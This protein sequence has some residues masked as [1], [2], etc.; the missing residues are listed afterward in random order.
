MEQNNISLETIRRELGLSQNGTM[1]T[2]SRTGET[3]ADDLVWVNSDGAGLPAVTT[4]VEDP[5]QVMKEEKELKFGTKIAEMYQETSVKFDEALEE[6]PLNEFKLISI[7]G[8]SYV[9][10]RNSDDEY[11]Y[12]SCSSRN[13]GYS[14]ATRDRTEFLRFVLNDIVHEKSIQLKKDI[15]EPEINSAVSL[16]E[17]LSSDDFLNHLG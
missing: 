6:F 14:L 16:S 5:I 17:V 8:H 12:T 11:N 3:E 1:T 10:S 9:A 4:P 2:T 13:F 15:F 7:D